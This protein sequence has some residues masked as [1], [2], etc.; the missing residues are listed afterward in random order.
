MKQ[1][2]NYRKKTGKVT[3]MWKL[4]NMLQNNQWFKAIKR[5]IENYLETF[6]NEKYNLPKHRMQPT[7][8]SEARCQ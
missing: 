3:Y 2:I 8:F 5:E 7:Q 4:N 6:E 1:E